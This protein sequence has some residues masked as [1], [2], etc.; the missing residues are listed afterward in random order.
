MQRRVFRSPVVGGDLHQDV[1][2]AGLG[3]FDEDIEIAVVVERA[4]VDQLELGNLPAP[5]PVLFC[6]Q[7]VGKRA[8]GILVEH[9]EIGV[10][11]RGVEVII[12]FLHVLAV[13]GFAVGESEQPFLEEGVLL[14][15]Q[16]Q[17]QA[18]VL[19]LVAQAGDA[20]LAPAVGAAARLVVGEVI[21]G[22]APRAVVLAHSPPLAFAEVRPPAPPLRAV[23]AL[24]EDAF[25]FRRGFAARNRHIRSPP[26]S[27]DHAG[28]QRWIRRRFSFEHSNPDWPAKPSPVFPPPDPPVIVYAGLETSF[29]Q[30][31]LPGANNV[32]R[33]PTPAPYQQGEE[34]MK[35]QKWLILS[36]LM[37][38]MNGWAA[39]EPA[40]KPADGAKASS[41]QKAED[42]AKQAAEEAKAATRKAA[43][44]A[45]V[46]MEK[47]E[48]AVSEASQKTANA[49]R[50]AARDA[51][52]AAKLAASKAGEATRKATA[53]TKAAAQDVEQA[54]K[55][56]AVAAQG[57]LMKAEASAKHAARSGKTVA[58]KAAEETRD[59]ARKAMEATKAAADKAFQ[60]SGETTPN[61]QD[62]EKK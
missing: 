35:L 48:L 44:A 56:A 17:S 37:A 27:N 41:V 46:A 51:E 26:S 15:P 7:R 31:G 60:A 38:G 3:V 50:E 42:A 54:A 45:K 9:L 12:E 57:A 52:D 5:A 22:V 28:Q 8:L 2:R 30:P 25:L 4:A 59:A 43:E 58:L 34:A 19:V 23:V 49:A 36:A 16:R 32:W 14:V 11:G 13:V 53:A 18:Q 6:Q 40:T 29:C 39:E 20:V 61:P 62:T 1:V 24:R 21:P 10:G 55:K 33:R 47:A